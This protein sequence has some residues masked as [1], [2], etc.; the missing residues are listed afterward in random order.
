MRK[1]IPEQGTGWGE[2]EPRLERFSADAIDWR[3]G[4]TPLYVFLATES[5]YEVGRK[6]FFKF[7]S[8][9]AL[10]GKRA[11]M[12]LKRMEDEI[13]E[14]AL[15][16]FSAPAD[17]AGN[18]ST[19]GSES[20]FLAVK[21]AR[22]RF[23]AL[24]PGLRHELNIV[25]PFSAHPA[26]DKAGQAMDVE[27]RR[28]PLRPDLRA[29]P[30]AMEHLTDERTFML[31][32]SAPCFPHGLID[33][34]D[35]LSAL[36]LRTDIW[37]HVDACV[38]GYVAPFVR[39]AG[40]P[41]PDFDFRLTGVR[42]ISAD[43]HKFGFCPKPASTVFYRF[44]EDYER[45]VFDFE[46]WPSGRFVT[47]MLTGTRAGGAVA[48]AWA[49]LHHLGVEGYC[50]IARDLMEMT[51]RYV[52]GIEE[53][54]GLRLH[55]PPDLTLVNFGSDELDIFAVAESMQA[56]GWLPGLTR[57]PRGMHLMMSLVHEGAREDWLKDLREA[58]CSARAGSAGTPRLQASY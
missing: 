38:G 9:N 17:A 33:P 35:E 3:R 10:G 46:D 53:I 55:A 8:E 32:G 39:R 5:A 23:R 50:A 12:G 26:F 58:V 52:K 42:S 19:G 22:E 36:A 57:R 6:A 49:V 13:V 15:S 40:Y 24:R 25:V 21:A 51:R 48:A 45:Q 20:I 11:F 27:V 44:R 47:P 31:A 30:A 29:D 34:L 41:L 56:R 54:E 4:R 14:M 7:F 18:L 43:L 1:T 28:A 37:L 16:L 2:L